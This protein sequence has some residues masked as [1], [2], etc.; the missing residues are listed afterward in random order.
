[1]NKQTVQPN[2]P[3]PDASPTL[4]GHWL[5]LSRAAWL[6]IT[7]GGV[8]LFAV[9]AQLY[10]QQ[11]A[12]TCTGAD[13]LRQQLAPEGAA[14]AAE[15]GL[16]LTEYAFFQ[17]MPTVLFAIV[18][19][20]IGALIFWQRAHERMAYVSSLW[21]VTFGLT[22]F[23]EEVLAAGAA[24]PALQPAAFVLIS[25]GGTILLPLFFFI[26]PNGRFAP[27][28]T[29]WV[30]LLISALF[31]CLGAAAELF[32][33]FTA[34]YESFSGYLW[35]TMLLGSIAMQIYRYR[36]LSTATERQQTKWVIFA[37]LVIV[38]VFVTMLLANPFFL[39]F[40]VQQAENA[41]GNIIG[42]AIGSSAFLMIPLG[43]GISIL[44]HRLFDIDLIIRRTVQYSI[45]SALL[46]AFILAALRS[47]RQ[48]NGRYRHPI[49][50]R[51]RALHPACRCPV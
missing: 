34:T 46:A 2:L 10:F 22:L 28:W 6:L 44:R 21:L 38:V 30:W 40:R 29:K 42:N 17:I 41:V 16:T 36:T 32:P 19:V 49:P 50:H 4:E 37:F 33:S 15:I 8:A 47:S 9:G 26:F 27:H 31:F 25:L 12:T 24:Y 13:C 7:V 51:H 20:A 23:E 48:R 39:D 18:S 11:L 5:T 35:L 1:M 45:V 43:I 14:A 3:A